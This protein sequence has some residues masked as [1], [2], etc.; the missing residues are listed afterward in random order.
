MNKNVL[1]IDDED[2]VARSLRLLLNSIGYKVDVAKSAAD[3]LKKVEEGNY[4]L[5]ICDVRMPD[6]DGVEAI[7]RIR[8]YLQ[9]AEREAIPEILITGY[10][11]SQKYEE[12]MELKV[13]DYLYK[14]FESD[15]LL[16]AVQKVIG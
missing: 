13:A 10:A 3:G 4:D 1:V 9:E 2:L 16:R 14:P 12:A 7:K 15:E 8:T 5:I 11:D 6:M